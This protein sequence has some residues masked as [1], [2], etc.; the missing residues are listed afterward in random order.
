[1]TRAQSLLVCTLAASLV[2]AAC[3]SS[4]GKPAGPAHFDATTGAAAVRALGAV[5]VDGA[6]TF[7]A[8]GNKIEHGSI[9]GAVQYAP[10]RTHEHFPV[11]AGVVLANVEYRRIDNRAWLHAAESTQLPSLGIPSVVVRP[12]GYVRRWQTIAAEAQGIQG[13]I[14]RP[15]DPAD[16]LAAAGKAKVVFARDGQGHVA[17][18]S[19][20]RFTARIPAEKV[21]LIG[22]KTLSVYT[23]LQGLPLRLDFTTLARTDGSYTLTKDGAAVTVDPPDPNQIEIQEKTPTATG[24]YRE[25]AHGTAGTVTYRVLRAGAT[26]GW[27]CWKVV[28]TPKFVLP[29]NAGKDG[30]ECVHGITLGGDSTDQVAIPLDASAE[31]SYELLGLQLPPGSSV[32]MHLVGGL[33]RLVPVTAGG[34]AVYVG[35]PSPAAGLAVVTL[36]DK[37]V[38]YCSPGDVNTLGDLANVS[39]GSTLRNDP[40]NCLDKDLA[41][42]LGG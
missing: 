34:L 24:P 28:S 20:A 37:A 11:G 27:A 23:D 7:L 30:G 19:R 26:K 29:R 31:T 21:G 13:A 40:W 25:V 36:P 4:S 14:V 8:A 1:V 32:V 3:S 33:Q 5:R 18:A 2:L 38:L 10:R 17:G 9:D 15:F 42:S 39:D 41:E 6:A 16:L 35:P 12:F 22:V